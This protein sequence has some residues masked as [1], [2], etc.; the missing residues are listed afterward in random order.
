MAKGPNGTS[1]QL[2]HS[3]FNLENMF[4]LNVIFLSVVHSSFFEYGKKSL[5]RV[6]G[7]IPNWCI[8]NHR[9][10]L[11]YTS[12]M[13]LFSPS[14]CWSIFFTEMQHVFWVFE[15]HRLA[16]VNA[17]LL[18]FYISSV[19]LFKNRDLLMSWRGIQHKRSLSNDLDFTF[20]VLNLRTHFYGERI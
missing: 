8:R 19:T 12:D 1:I 5:F 9:R 10:L 17:F 6:S 3:K 13:L 15:V 18:Q 16:A 11:H 4:H 20:Y 2:L 7:K 14:F